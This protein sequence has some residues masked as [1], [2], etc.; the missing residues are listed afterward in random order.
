LQKGPHAGI[1]ESH[2]NLVKRDGECG[3]QG[4]SWSL[5]WGSGLVVASTGISKGCN[6]LWSGSLALVLQTNYHFAKFSTLA[7]GRLASGE[8]RPILLKWNKRI[9][10]D[11]WVVGRDA[12]A[13]GEA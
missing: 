2:F 12:E 8:A 10:D 3:L 13:V 1:L 11:S 9:E 5:P 6:Y 7:N 4:R